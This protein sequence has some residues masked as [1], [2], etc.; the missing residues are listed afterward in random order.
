MQTYI[1]FTAR[2]MSI[3]FQPHL[4][5]SP[6]SA[7]LKILPKVQRSA[8]SSINLYLDNFHKGDMS[9]NGNIIIVTYPM[10]LKNRYL[11]RKH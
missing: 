9:D 4:P 8:I 5:K 10:Q 2:K 3:I 6:K 7:Q 11:I 1:I